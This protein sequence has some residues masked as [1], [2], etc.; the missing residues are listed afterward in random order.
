MTFYYGHDSS[1]ANQDKL[2]AILNKLEEPDRPVAR[3]PTPAP[4]PEAA[5]FG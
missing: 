3:L 5:D 4:T 1:E 2:Q